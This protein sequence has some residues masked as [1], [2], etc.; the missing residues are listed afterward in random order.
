MTIA[1]TEPS[2]SST[3]AETADSP[4]SKSSKFVEVPD[5]STFLNEPT[6]EILEKIQNYNFPIFEFA[7]LCNNRPLFVMSH[8]L[9]VE[10]GLLDKV[11]VPAQ[12][13]MNY[14]FSVENGYRPS[15]TCKSF[16]T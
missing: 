1:Q 13:F 11:K 10:S 4:T 2:Q 16:L 9:I 6:R 15:L 5:I 12:K 7:K 3:T 8:Q 14:M